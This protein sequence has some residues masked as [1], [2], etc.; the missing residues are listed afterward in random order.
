[1]A[2]YQKLFKN[3]YIDKLISSL[4]SGE[5]LDLYGK[6]SFDYDAENV[7]ENKRIVVTELPELT[8]PENG[9]FYEYENAVKLFKYLPDLNRTQATDKRIWTFLSH[10]PYWQYLKARWPLPEASSG[11]RKIITHILD[12][13]FLE[14]SKSFSRHGIASLWWGGFITYDDKKENPFVLTR[15]F[16]S[17]QD[18]KRVILEENICF[19]KPLVHAI[20]EYIIENKELFEIQWAPK[21]R[22]LIRKLNFISGYK[23]LSSLP[24][25]TIKNIIE[26][27]RSDIMNITS[28]DKSEI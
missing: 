23:I 24:K 8:I 20:L 19:Y 14:G 3:S 25:S 1:M 12:H 28:G 9:Q 11:K 4:K 21:V 26:E 17:K 2:Q 22:F 6:T 18:Y 5:N 16:F 15:E 10:G 27:F 13:W 7:T